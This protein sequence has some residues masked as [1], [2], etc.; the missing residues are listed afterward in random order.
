[1]NFSVQASLEE[2]GYNMEAISD[3]LREALNLQVGQLALAAKGEW[4]RLAQDRLSTTREIYV[5]GLRQAESFKVMRSGGMAS[6]EITL[7]GVMPNN[8]EY[9][10]GP[11][12]MKA[13]R[14]GW[15]G[16]KA[17]KLG[18]NGKRYVVIPFRHST[19]S[20]S[21]FD[22]TGKAKSVS[23][24]DLKT[25]LKKAVKTYGLDRMI[26]TATGQVVSGTHTS[27]NSG[28]QIPN[29]VAKLPK[30]ASVHPYLQGMIRTQQAYGSH[31]AGTKQKG[32]GSL[33]TFRIMS[34]NSA[35]SSWIHP[36]LK[37]VN[38]LAEVEQ[39]VEN[40]MMK[41]ANNILGDR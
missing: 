37:A 12:D 26:R 29:T 25:Q 3:G 23:D 34:E 17:S 36:G 35:P 14:P 15:L 11:Y 13:V 8:I 5:N 1:M 22:Y 32:G 30:T 41:I 33:M 40:E 16:G 28:L 27:R 6:Y 18:K 38:L 20:S 24:P 7:V 2:L 31:T 39:F 19:A 10:Q 9:G 4:I 21:R